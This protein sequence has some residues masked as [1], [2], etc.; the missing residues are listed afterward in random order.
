MSIG[1]DMQVRPGSTQQLI[2]LQKKIRIARTAKALVTLS[3]CFKNK[4]TTNVQDCNQEWGM[5]TA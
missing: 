2:L 1:D 4:N 5:G 3:K